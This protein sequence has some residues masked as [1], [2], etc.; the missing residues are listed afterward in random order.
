MGPVI[1][2]LVKGS[3]ALGDQ[4]DKTMEGRRLVTYFTIQYKIKSTEPQINLIWYLLD[5]IITK[6]Y[7][8]SEFHDPVKETGKF[9]HCFP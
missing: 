5:S 8:C 2:Q 4:R 3:K 7:S 1:G 9:Q 6:K